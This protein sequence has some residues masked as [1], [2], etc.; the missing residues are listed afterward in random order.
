MKVQFIW[1]NFDCPIGPSIGLAYLSGALK[2]AG[3]ETNIIHISDG[4]I[5]RLTLTGS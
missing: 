5:M 3:H 1:P 2:R 4:W